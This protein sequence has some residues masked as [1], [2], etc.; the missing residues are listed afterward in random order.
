MKQKEKQKKENNSTVKVKP[1]FPAHKINMGS[2][3]RNYN[4]KQVEMNLLSI[5]KKMIQVQVSEYKN[6][7]C[8][9]FN[10]IIQSMMVGIMIF[11]SSIL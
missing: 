10:G 9:R 3:I 8:P 1:N 4:R 11:V 2:F 6:G 5:N 7:N